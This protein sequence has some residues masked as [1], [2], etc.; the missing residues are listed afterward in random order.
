MTVVQC[1]HQR[2]VAPDP[3]APF[4][5]VE[6]GRQ[7]AMAALGDIGYGELID[8]A[9]ERGLAL[10]SLPADEFDRMAN[11]FVRLLTTAA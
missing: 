11:D 8:K 1:P 3:V 7:R 4:A 6:I 9:A 5:R 2:L 10:S